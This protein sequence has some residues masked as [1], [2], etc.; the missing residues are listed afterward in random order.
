M[1]IRLNGL[2]ILW[3]TVESELAACAQICFLCA[4]SGAAK[5]LAVRNG[6][7]GREGKSVS[8]FPRL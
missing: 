6:C 2:G 3:L 5:R 7:D 8:F 4:V 1:T